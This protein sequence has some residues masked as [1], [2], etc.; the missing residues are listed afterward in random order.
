MKEVPADGVPVKGVPVKGVPVKGVPVKGVQS[1]MVSRM[2]P[3]RR[4]SAHAGG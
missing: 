2:H 4:Y 1:G 3:L